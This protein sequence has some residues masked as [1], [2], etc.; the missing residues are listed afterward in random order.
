MRMENY[1]Y[2]GMAYTCENFQVA[3]T[4]MLQGFVISQQVFLPGIDVCSFP[5]QEQ[6]LRALRYLPDVVALQKTLA[7][8][9][10]RR[11]DREKAGRLK[12][13]DFFKD[14]TRGLLPFFKSPFR[15]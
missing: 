9:F 5:L 1:E 3:V 13:D 11:I 7:D 10:H 15:T 4:K 12:I 14:L 6:K 2:N 8:R